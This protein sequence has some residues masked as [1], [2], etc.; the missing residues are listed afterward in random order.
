[1]RSP[2]A[3]RL[4]SRSAARQAGQFGALAVT[5]AATLAGTLGV[6]LT[7]GYAPPIGASTAFLSAANV[8]GQF[9]SVVNVTAGECLLLQCKLFVQRRKHRGQRAAIRRSGGHPGTRA[10]SIGGRPA[11][12]RDLDGDEPR[13]HG[14]HGGLAG[15]RLP[16]VGRTRSIPAPFSWPRWP[17]ARPPRWQRIA[18]TRPAP[19]LPFR[20]DCRR[21]AT[22]CWSTPIIDQTQAESNYSNNVR[23]VGIH[24]LAA[25]AGPAR[26][27]ALRQSG[28]RPTVRRQPDCAAGT[29][30]TTGLARR[31]PPSATRCRSSTR[32][33]ARPWPRPSFPTTSRSR[34][35]WPQAVPW[36]S[37]TRSSCPTARRG[38]DRSRSPSPTTSTTRSPSSIRTARP[39]R[40][41]RQ[42][43]PRPRPWPPIPTCTPRRWP[44]IRRASCSPAARSPSIGTTATW[45]MPRPA[46][47][48]TTR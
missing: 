30:P 44:S 9:S 47:V 14:D 18:A 19:P 8:A 25:A 10:Q 20:W 24:G 34:V 40:A 29:T 46:G 1:M 48:G 12:D 37:S 23:S 4:S 7:G 35:L 32:R 2:P 27:G 41:I 15:R 16:L 28:Q 21:G 43:L 31:R 36:P 6:D 13:E 39:R 45:A 3:P 33:P 5:G 17:R 26:H 42:P 38:W 11:G 22:P